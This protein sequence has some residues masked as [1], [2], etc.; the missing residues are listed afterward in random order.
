MDSLLV[1]I[2]NK[3]V[4]VMLFTDV[5]TYRMTMKRNYTIMH[6]AIC[7]QIQVF[8]EDFN[9][10]VA[11]FMQM[12]EVHHAVISGSHMLHMFDPMPHWQPSDMDLCI[13]RF[14]ACRVIL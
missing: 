14:W 13:L 11:S 10:L 8:M 5:V 6:S 7:K 2:A 12:L 1:E 4:A 9:V 3:V